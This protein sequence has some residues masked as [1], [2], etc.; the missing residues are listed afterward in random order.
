MPRKIVLRQGISNHVTL[1]F[2]WFAFIP[3][4][5]ITRNRIHASK[6]LAIPRQETIPGGQ[7]Y[8]ISLQFTSMHRNIS[9]TFTQP[10]NLW[11]EHII[12]VFDEMD[13]TS[14]LTCHLGDKPKPMVNG[15]VVLTKNYADAF[16]FS[17]ISNI[18]NRAG[19]NS[20][21]SH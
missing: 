6:C 9:E 17:R 5:N 18:S 19:T 4:A 13:W 21:V 10:L 7:M 15:Q 8:I 16:L 11:T 3:V 1:T 14:D 20:F 12:I 2:Q